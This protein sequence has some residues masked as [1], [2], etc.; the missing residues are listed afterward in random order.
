MGSDK[1]PCGQHQTFKILRMELLKAKEVKTILRCSE[2]LVYKLAARGQLPCV[3]IPCVGNGKR[4]KSL[5][6]FK[7]SDVLAFIEENYTNF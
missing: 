2:P 6:R 1:T 4:K 7:K 3:R 5:V